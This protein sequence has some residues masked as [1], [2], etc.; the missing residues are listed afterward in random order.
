MREAHRGD[1]ADTGIRHP[2]PAV[3]DLLKFGRKPGGLGDRPRFLEAEGRRRQI[4]RPGRPGLLLG[5]LQGVRRP[6]A[7]AGVTDEDGPLSEGLP[8]FPPRRL[9]PPISVR[10]ATVA[11][12]RV[13]KRVLA[14]AK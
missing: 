2:P 7:A 3:P 12:N 1:G 13:W 14:R 9:T 4:E 6:A 8:D 5:L 11:T 10:L